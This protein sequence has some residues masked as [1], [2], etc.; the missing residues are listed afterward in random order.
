[1]RETNLSSPGGA[2]AEENNKKNKNNKPDINIVESELFEW[3]DSF[4]PRL[5]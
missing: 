2:Y 3:T 4:E 1:M 5:G